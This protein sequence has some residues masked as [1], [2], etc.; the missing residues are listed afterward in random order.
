MGCGVFAPCRSSSLSCCP[1]ELSP[2]LYFFVHCCFLLPAIAAE[3]LHGT[4]GAATA[5]AFRLP[6]LRVL[7]VAV[8]CMLFLGLPTPSGATPT[9][10]LRFRNIV[11]SGNASVLALHQD[12]AGFVWVGTQSGGLLRH[13]GIDSIKY[14]NLAGNQRSLPHNRVYAIHEDEAGRI[15]VGTRAGMARFDPLTNDFTRFYPPGTDAKRLNV[16]SIISDGAG[17]L[18]IATWGGIQHL[19]LTSGKFVRYTHQEGDSTSLSYDD[20]NAL[21][22]DGRG[23]LWAATWPGGLDY[24][25]AGTAQFQHFRVDQASHPDP[26][27]NNVR[28]LRFDRN[29]TLWMGTESGILTWED[30]TAWASRTREESPQVRINRLY[31]DNRGTLWAGTLSEGLLAYMGRHHK[32]VRYLHRANDPYSLPADNVREILVDRSG[33]LWAGTFTDGIGVASLNTKGLAR[34]I[35]FD[36]PSVGIKRSNALTALADAGSGGLWLGGNSGLA[37]FVPASGEVVSAYRADGRRPGA[38][39]SDMIYSLYMG[40]DGVLWVGTDTGLNRFDTRSGK[41]QV[42]HFGSRAEDFINSISSGRAGSLWLGTGSSVIQYQPASGRSRRFEHNPLDSSSRS[43]QGAN[44][45]VEDR[46]GRVW[47]G[48]EMSGG[49]LDLLD[50]VSGN[51]Q[52]FLHIEGDPTSL[53]SDTVTSIHEDSNGRIWVGT[54]KGINE[55]VLS[56]AQRVRFRSFQGSASV[57]E[58]RVLAIMSDSD[59]QIWLSTLGGLQRLD[60]ASGNSTKF[61]D[62]DGISDSYTVGAAAADRAGAIYFGGLR[63]MTVVQPRTVSSTSLPPQV[64]ISN[65]EV[66]NRA[67]TLGVGKTVHVSGPLSAPDALSL[68]VDDPVL[69]I[70]F[71]ALDFNDPAKNRF[72]YRLEGFDQSWVPADALHRRATYAK[73]APE[74]YLFRVRATNGKGIDSQNEARMVIVVRPPYWM[75]WWFRGGTGVSALMLAVAVYFWKIRRMVRHQNELEALVAERTREIKEANHKL[76]T[77]ALTDGL[78]QICNRRGFD[79]ALLR[80]W[81][82]ALRDH[83][84]LSVILLDVDYFKRYNDHYGHPAGDACLRAIAE[85]LSNYARRP[86]DVIARYG[87]E[88]FVVLLPETGLVDAMR[89]AAAI[90]R[91]L[92]KLAMPHDD[93]PHGR[94]TISAGVAGGLAASDIPPESLIGD[95]DEA[96]YVAKAA[97]R[98][99]AASNAVA[100][101]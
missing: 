11:P 16:K 65:V 2:V 8:C 78:T 64:A 73:L 98:N 19:N 13:D 18:W 22:L 51:I 36:E 54:D 27:Q 79:M 37:R 35:P 82:R 72:E 53:A 99:R 10:A 4:L 55:I 40:L 3:V 81:P 32:P 56:E 95:A 45:V 74:T 28:S 31:L 38:L 77:L 91:A 58:T 85:L 75:T 63:G 20:V 6:S 57:G 41:F 101:I 87:G 50:P 42:I 39:G 52:H 67:L 80:E 33:V 14:T 15:W 60:P 100:R 70:E 9:S 76:E 29:S 24:L 94:V 88:E 12:R 97:G 46:R 44:C 17:G 49:G 47:I 59:G 84:E 48:S 34:I 71:A 96:L 43:V 62:A 93:S 21:A 92:E 89:I 66:L 5:R 25:P 7:G 61:I 68:S 1:D 90:C 30:G 69:S 83:C 26:R 86:A 23:G